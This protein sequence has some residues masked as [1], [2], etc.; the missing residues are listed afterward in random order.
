L[1]RPAFDLCGGPVPAPPV[2]REGVREGDTLRTSPGVR[3]RVALR[4]DSV[5]F[6]SADAELKLD[7]L[8]Q[9]A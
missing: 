4:D 3:L 7:H 9:S 1:G 8:A 6:L 5:L 2:L